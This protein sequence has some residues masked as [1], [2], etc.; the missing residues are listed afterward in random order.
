MFAKAWPH[1]LAFE[2]LPAGMVYE[3][4]HDGYVGQ[5][6]E[7][8]MHTRRFAH[9]WAEGRLTITDHLSGAGEH[10]AICHFRLDT[11]VVLRLKDAGGA[12]LL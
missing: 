10:E 11:A 12:V 6:A 1:H 3:G 9:D 8:V 5:L 4:S 7:G 2:V